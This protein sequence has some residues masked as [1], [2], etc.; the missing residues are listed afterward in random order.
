ME[1]LNEIATKAGVRLVAR[2]EGGRAR[3]NPPAGASSSG[4]SGGEYPAGKPR[5]KI[6]EVLCS[7]ELSSPVVWTNV[8]EEVILE[9]IRPTEVSGHLGTPAVVVCS[10]LM[11]GT[12]CPKKYNYDCPLGF[13]YGSRV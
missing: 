4:A 9:Q 8:D 1:V 7:G 5:V 3:S 2:V 11:A 13:S 12:Y 10:S 6:L